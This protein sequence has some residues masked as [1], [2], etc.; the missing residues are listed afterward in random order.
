MG[1]LIPNTTGIDS[2]LQPTVGFSFGLPNNGNGNKAYGNQ[3]Q[4]FLGTGSGANPYPNSG[5]FSIGALDIAPLV[6]FQATTNDEGELVNKPLINLHVTPNG[7]GIFGCEDELYPSLPDPSGFFNSQ[8]PQEQYQYPQHNHY[9]N[10]RRHQQQQSTSQRRPVTFEQLTPSPPIY[11]QQ[12]QQPQYQNYRP[13]SPQQSQYH[14][15]NQYN[16]GPLYNHQVPEY[17]GHH[18][19]NSNYNP[20]KRRVQSSNNVRFGGDS[21]TSN[22]GVVKHVHEHHHY[23]HDEN[24]RP[25]INR[26]QDHISYHN[27]PPAAYFRTLN[28]TDS[29]IFVI[30][31]A[32]VKDANERE[33]K[34]DLAY[35]GEEEKSGFKFPKHHP[36]SKRS[37]DHDNHHQVEHIQP[38]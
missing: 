20:K 13:P 11:Q 28:D 14:Q 23:H 3:P 16:Q 21:A 25:T 38:V 2:K 34:E 19:T 17:D 32:I 10:T 33:V 4:N 5:G 27:Q 7:C 24:P 18:Q 26:F 1:N 35:G 30:E 31:D 9:Q 36:K 12:Q 37:A 6:S 15:P 8:Y 29:D 22:E